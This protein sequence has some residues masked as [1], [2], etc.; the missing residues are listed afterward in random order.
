[1]QTPAE[2]IELQRLI[3]EGGTH[4]SARV[5]C[6]VDAGGGADGGAAA[7]RL[8]VIA[9]ALGNPAPDIPAVGFFGGVH[10]LERIGSAVVMAHL[11]SLV[12]RL[13]W[14]ESLHRQLD[15]V[16]MV[17]MPVVNP[18][19][20]A[21]GTRA[22]PQGV[23]LM[24][25]AP[26]DARDRVPFLLGGQRLSASLPWYRGPAGAPMQPESAAL[27]RVVEEDLLA[28][29]FS[30]TVDCHSG[31]GLRDRL[32]FPYAHTRAPMAHLPEMDALH[33]IFQQSHPNNR[34]VF[35]PQSRQYLAHGDL[36]DHLYQRASA[37]PQRLLLPLTLE[38]GSWLW[39]KKNPRQLFS[40]HGIFNPLIAHRQ[41]RVLRQH[42]ALL[43]FLA[44][45]AASW[46]RWLPS[47]AS[48]ERHGQLA[49]QRWYGAGASS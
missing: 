37:L 47:S 24:R 32:W 6:E 15:G 39:V 28:R 46:Q 20:I 14:D 25:N 43:D 10:G 26:V 31:F 44:R 12:M 22:N 29:P 3:D 13:R 17:F 4:L 27:C 33:G 21:R 30:L 1:M 40:R 18:G 8:P 49:L 7:Q 36:W 35:E 11:R 9:V 34:Y 41:Q 16:R 48:R 19:G 2:L 23:D 42:M 45:A 5:L 38:M